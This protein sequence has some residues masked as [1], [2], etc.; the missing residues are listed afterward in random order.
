MKRAP[1]F[2]KHCAIS[3]NELEVPRHLDIRNRTSGD[4]RR[5]RLRRGI[6]RWHQ[7]VCADGRGVRRV[8]IV[9]LTIAKPE[10]LAAQGAIMEFWHSARVAF[11]GLRYFSWAELQR[12]GA[13]H[14]H[15]I[16]LNPVWRTRGQAVRWIRAHWRHAGITPHVEFKERSWFVDRGRKYV[17]AYAKKS[18]P[19]RT[20]SRSG[21]KGYQQD[22]DQM[23]RE[24]RTF[25]HQVLAHYVADLD[26]HRTRGVVDY[27]GP[28]MARWYERI[29][30]YWIIYVDRHL[31]GDGP[32]K[33]PFRHTRKRPRQSTET[34]GRSREVNRARPTIAASA[35][36]PLQSTV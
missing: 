3:R 25:Q 31:D 4:R 11:P 6:D 9:T 5:A 35:G 28:L 34:L 36:F 22:Y 21:S 32:C 12:R 13:V 33:I 27:L 14:Y 16:W 8:A 29:E 15:A 24:I 7:S 30:H 1:V 18:P 26:A 17:T 23:P 10:P 19:L 20:A 2:L